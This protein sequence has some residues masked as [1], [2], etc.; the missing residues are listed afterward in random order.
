[1]WQFLKRQQKDN[2]TERRK[3]LTFSEIV[4]GMGDFSDFATHDAALKFW[5]PEPAEQVLREMSERSDLS[6]SELL[7]QFLAI[8]CYGL[9]AFY[10]M[11]DI[12]PKLFKEGQSDSRFS[13]VA[14]EPPEYKKRV[15][16]YWVPELGKNV[17]AIKVWIPK[18]VKADLQT[19]AEH[20]E[21]TP[22]NYVREI[23]ISR[24]LGHGM[25]P[26]RPTMF[27]A[28]PTSATN[29][30]EE[31]RDVPWREISQDAF[32]SYSIGERRTEWV[33]GCE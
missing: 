1:M 29:D 24:L 15:D 31:N 27:K 25:L 28:F 8:H 23:L 32:H 5:L 19:L 11:T 10:Q 13:M 7:R 14:E 6:V 3:P 26:S 9:Y 20:V 2:Q 16:T 12:M 33:D 30:W 18:R 21:L 17:A 4:V 22:S